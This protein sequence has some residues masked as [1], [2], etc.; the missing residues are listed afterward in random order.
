MIYNCNI[1]GMAAVLKLEDKWVVGIS[2]SVLFDLETE[3]HIYE[4]EGL[5]AYA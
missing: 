2:S 5:D 3:N 4:T 1:G